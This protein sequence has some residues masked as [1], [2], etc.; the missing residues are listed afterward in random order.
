MWILSGGRVCSDN[1]LHVARPYTGGQ[2][3]QYGVRAAV[4]EREDSTSRPTMMLGDTRAH[5]AASASPANLLRV[6][7]W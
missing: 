6:N 1:W 2:C 7:A 5:E 4:S 3:L